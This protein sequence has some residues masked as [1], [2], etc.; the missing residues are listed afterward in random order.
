MQTIY[1]PN[2]HYYTQWIL[3]DYILFEIR[4]FFSKS[5]VLLIWLI[6]KPFHYV[7]DPGKNI[8]SLRKLSEDTEQKQMHEEWALGFLVD[9]FA[10]LLF[11]YAF[12]QYTLNSFY[13]PNIIQDVDDMDTVLKVGF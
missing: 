6:V 7:S 8:I 11:I 9:S 4:H 3:V 1:Q 13:V 10:F 2:S 12:N 5:S